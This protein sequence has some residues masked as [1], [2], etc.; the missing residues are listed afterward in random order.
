MSVSN[1]EHV[2]NHCVLDRLLLSVKVKV[3]ESIRYVFS[4]KK[5]VVK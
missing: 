2:V 1:E 4:S 3:R 5:N